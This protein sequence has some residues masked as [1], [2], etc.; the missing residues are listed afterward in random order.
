MKNSIYIIILFLS[1]TFFSCEDVLEENPT[2][3]LSTE[4]TYNTDVGLSAGVVGIYDEMSY[5]Y[6]SDLKKIYGIQHYGQDVSEGGR[7][8]SDALALY[9]SEFRS[10]L[11]EFEVTWEHYYRLV[12][13]ATAVIDHSLT[14]EWDDADLGDF[15]NGQAYFFRAYGHFMLTSLWGDV[16]VIKEETTGVKLDFVRTPQQEVFNFVIEDLEAAIDLLPVSESQDGRITKGAA[17]HLLA[18]TYLANEQWQNALDYA[19]AVIAGPYALM[20]SRYG[21][22]ADDTAQSVFTDLFELGNYN[23]SEGNTEAIWVL[24]FENQETYPG[25]ASTINDHG[26]NY[27]R[28]FWMS[29]Y[30]RTGVIALSEEYGGRGFNRNQ[31][32]DYFLELF[33]VS[34]I[35]GQEAALRRTWTYNDSSLLPDGKQL[36]DTVEIT[37]SFEPHMHPVVTKFDYFLNEDNASL[38]SS[39]KDIYMFRLAET[40]LI[41]AEAQLML[42]QTT[43]AAATINIVRSRASAPLITAADVDIDF[44]LDERAR[45]LFGEAPRRI[46]LTRTGKFLERV[47]DLNPEAYP[48]DHHVLLPIPQSAIDLNSEA[49]YGQNEG[50]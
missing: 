49:E 18:Y 44:I 7:N 15:V 13:K 50:Y 47:R 24:Q 30:E 21:I 26:V 17:Q 48:L 28:R 37:A 25:T 34:D 8:P 22:Y 1:T 33:D 4:T 29:P 36:G 19:D 11:D 12:N 46:D 42:N 14:H 3:F 35:R 27:T 32:T 16:S 45:E 41:K 39:Y 38:S 40:Y 2:T 23:Y 5:A 20:T 9:D 31:A 10:D 43:E 6:S